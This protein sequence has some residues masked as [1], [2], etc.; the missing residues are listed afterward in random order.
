MYALPKKAGQYYQDIVE[1]IAEHGA[2]AAPTVATPVALTHDIFGIPLAPGPTAPGPNLFELYE[3]GGIAAVNKAT[4][5][6]SKHVVQVT[7]E[8][9]KLYQDK[10]GHTKTKINE[11]ALKSPFNEFRTYDEDSAKQVLLHWNNATTPYALR[12]EELVW[13]A[14][15]SLIK[16]G[17]LLS[18]KYAHD[19][20][21]TIGFLPPTISKAYKSFE[22]KGYT[23]A[24]Q[25]PPRG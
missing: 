16:I 1:I 11:K 6:I 13:K 9:I 7:Q 25:G 18:L 15:P 10:M 19:Y 14:K 4:E 20:N 8:E 23:L 12:Q 17:E 3:K 5:G 22:K 2:H 24:G 21:M